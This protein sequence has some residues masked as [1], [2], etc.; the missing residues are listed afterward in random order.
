M[1]WFDEDNI[2]DYSIYGRDFSFALVN[3][4]F[5]NCRL[6]YTT[7]RSEQL[8]I[9]FSAMSEFE[10]R[11]PSRNDNTSILNLFIQIRDE[12]NCISEYNMT[13]VIVTLDLPSISDLINTLGSSTDL[14]TKNSFVQLLSSE[15]QNI[16]GQIIVSLSQQFN[17][18]NTESLQNATSSKYR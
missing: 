17:K 4:Q 8:I 7:D 6:G 14:L 18:I 10:V 13:S 16:V 5:N 9:G 1:N 2:I 15:N 12:F 3:F 11:L